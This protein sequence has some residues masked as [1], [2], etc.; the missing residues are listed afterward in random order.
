[1]LLLFCYAYL[2]FALYMPVVPT[3]ITA[4]LVARS[5]TIMEVQVVLLTGTNYNLVTTS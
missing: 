5:V 2:V 3:A 4:V 1:M